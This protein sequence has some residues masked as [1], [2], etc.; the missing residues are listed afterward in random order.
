MTI[1][2]SIPLIV[3]VS[4]VY[5][6]SRYEMPVVILTHAVKVA[7]WIVGLMGAIYGILAAVML[8]L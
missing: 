5:S 8:M 2:Y 1:L 4:L 7:A 6:A 3:S